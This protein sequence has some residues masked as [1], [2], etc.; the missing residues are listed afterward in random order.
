[1]SG[2]ILP[3][4]AKMFD[5]QKAHYAELTEGI[6]DNLCETVGYVKEAEYSLDQ[7]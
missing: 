3:F 7:L 4:L 5:G 6:S 1:L 2:S